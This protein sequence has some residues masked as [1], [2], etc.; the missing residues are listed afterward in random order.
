MKNL[1][2]VREAR[3]AD[4]SAIHDLLKYY[5]ER[6]IVLPRSRDD[7][8]YY[9]NNFVVGEIESRICGC[10]AVRDFDRDL[11][12]V[13]SLAVDPKLHGRGVGCALVEAIVAGQRLKRNS[14]R[15]FALTY[16]KEFFFKQG[17]VLVNKEMFPEKI[18]SDCENCPKKDCC[19][20]DAVLY[21]WPSDKN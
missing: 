16:Q 2:T 12:E 9:L 6:Q 3:A 5:A 18:W 15:L 4:I 1:L 8:R 7:I 19:D 17:F 14:F 13:R 10:C 20:E 21:V 11:L